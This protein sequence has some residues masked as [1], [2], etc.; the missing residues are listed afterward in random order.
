MAIKPQLWTIGALSQEFGTDPRRM[1]RIVADLEPIK[2]GQRQYYKLR[3]VVD[4]MFA[5]QAERQPAKPKGVE[6]SRRRLMA[7]QAEQAELELSKARGEVVSVDE[8][9]TAFK[10]VI[11]STRARLLAVPPKAAPLVFNAASIA[12]A[13]RIIRTAIADA[14]NELGDAADDDGSGDGDAV[15]VQ[16]KGKASAKTGGSKRKGRAKT[17]AR[18]DGK[19]MGRSGPKTKPGS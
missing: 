19:S 5:D 14:L 1:G 10:G 16:R 6:E 2:K 7:A 13:E 15:Q 9:E 11:L 12:E 8:A 4:A 17:A 3:D 18:P